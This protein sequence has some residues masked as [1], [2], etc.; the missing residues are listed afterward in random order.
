MRVIEVRV[1]AGPYETVLSDEPRIVPANQL[2]IAVTGA[3]SRNALLDGRSI[4]FSSGSTGLFSIDLVRSTGFHHLVIDGAS[5]WFGTQDAKLGLD[6]VVAM[7]KDLGDL[8]T[9]WAGQAVFSDGLGFR[10]PHVSYGWLDQHGDDAL[11][12]ISSILEAPRTNMRSSRVLRRRGGSGVLLTPTL[13]LLRSDPRR[14]MVPSPNGV[15]KSGDERYEPLRVVARKRETTL[16]TVANVRA[17]SVL[18]WIDRLAQEVVVASD[19]SAAVARSRLW[20]NHARALLRRPLGQSLGIENIPLEPRQPEEITDP[21]YRTSFMLSQD[22]LNNFAWNASSPLTNRLSYVDHSDAI[23]QSYSASRLARELGLRQ[24]SLVLGTKQPA[25]SGLSFDLYYDTAPPAHVLRSW[26]SHSD[27]PDQS[28]PDL[29]LHERETGRIA[30][31]DAKYRIGRDGRASEDSRKEVSAYM[32]L[33]GLAAVSILYPGAE[34]TERVVAGK[35]RRILELS[36]APQVADIATSASAIISTLQ[37]P[38][39]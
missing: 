32:A 28:R 39:F 19:N 3:R 30:V 31:I 9:G 36:I 5:Y 7:L 15:I 26:R 37:N 2:V 13:R 22:L 29:L 23:Y 6:G 17:L 1:L 27:R 4:R 38:E 10:D 33:Y 20:S 11:A 12:A 35:G 34:Q 14:F 18:G 8:G 25:F 16:R 21:L 24:T